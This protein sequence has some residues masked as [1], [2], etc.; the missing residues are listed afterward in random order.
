MYS[1]YWSE[2]QE[3]AHITKKEFMCVIETIAKW[4]RY[5]T[6]RKFT[7]STDSKNIPYLFERSNKGLLELTQHQRWVELLRGYDFEIKHIPG[8]SN[9]V[10]DFL[11]RIYK[12]D[13]QRNKM[14]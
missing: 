14:K 1:K 10:A 12:D 4:K 13:L 6:T 11:S 2:P 5:L 3:K 8:I 7:I 9:K